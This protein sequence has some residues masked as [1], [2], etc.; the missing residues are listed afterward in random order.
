MNAYNTYRQTQAQTAAPGELIVML[1]RG[2]ARFVASAI[3]AIEAN[4]VEASH[5][6]LVRAQAVITELLESLNVEQGGEVG[7]NLFRLYEFMN[8][9]LV[10]ANLRKDPAPARDVERL[11]RELL[12]A[13]EEAV[14]LAGAGALRQPVSV[15][16]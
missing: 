1:Y 15:S 5:N 9:R 11:L 16:A 7:R 6:Q 14:R 8:Q 10:D 2:A 13:W 4:D 3:E 12:P